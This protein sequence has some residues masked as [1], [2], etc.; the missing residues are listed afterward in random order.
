MNHRYTSRPFTAVVLSAAVFAL[1]GLS[2]GRAATVASVFESGTNPAFDM[3][4]R[5][6][7][8]PDELATLSSHTNAIDTDAGSLVNA[9]TKD[10]PG[11]DADMAPDLMVLADA[12]DVTVDDMMPNEMKPATRDAINKADQ[13]MGFA[14]GN[15]DM[16]PDRDRCQ[17]GSRN[18]P[19]SIR[20]CGGRQVPGQ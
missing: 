4:D 1:S 6:R 17:R 11:Y 3:H 14:I 10:I 7:G 13:A 8:L 15:L 9:M 12:S 2:P 19:G 16:T 5:I 20:R 18:L